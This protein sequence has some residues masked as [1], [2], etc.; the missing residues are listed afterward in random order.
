[1]TA[2]ASFALFTERRSPTAMAGIGAGVIGVI[3]SLRRKPLLGIPLA[4]LGAIG[5]LT[6][7]QMLWVATA[8]VA[9]ALAIGLFARDKVDV[10]VEDTVTSY[11]DADLDT[12]VRVAML[13]VGIERAT[14]RFPLG[15]G[16]G[17]FGSYASV[18]FPSEVYET[19]GLWLLP[20]FSFEPDEPNYALDT[21]WQ[22]LLGEVGWI[23]TLAMALFMVS[24]LGRVRKARRNATTAECRTI[25]FFSLMVLIEALVESIAA[26]V[27]ESSLQA[28][29]IALALGVTLRLAPSDPTFAAGSHAKRPA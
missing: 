29:F 8:C 15:E 24:L 16:F 3:M 10:I 14:A 19:T 17:R 2:L 20:G 6:R 11:L 28:F 27:F 23:G 13:Y 4:V 18:L 7:R 1:V 26:P 21:Y 5:S 22:H 9:A 25:A 12:Q